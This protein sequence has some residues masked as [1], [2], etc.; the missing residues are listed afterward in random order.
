[1]EGTA[2]SERKVHLEKHDKGLSRVFIFLMVVAI[3]LIVIITYLNQDLELA[4]IAAINLL[5]M[6][7]VVTG[8]VAWVKRGDLGIITGKK[9]FIGMWLL[10]LAFAVIFTAVGY[11]SGGF[12]VDL[13]IPPSYSLHIEIVWASD[14][15]ANVLLAFVESVFIA[16]MSQLVIISVGFGFIWFSGWLVRTFLPSTLR[17]LNRATFTKSDPPTTL[18]LLWLMAIPRA[19]EP[20]SLAVEIGERPRT[21]SW[22]R[23]FW[24]VSWELFIGTILAIYIS[25]NP[26]LLDL[27]SITGLLST[28]GL[29]SVI[30]P[31]IVIPLFVIV[32]I[33]ARIPGPRAAFLLYHGI[34]SRILQTFVAL[35]T[36]FLLIRLALTKYDPIMI[37]QSFLSYYVILGIF[38]LYF[39]FVYLNFF[40]HDLAIKVV[41]D[42]KAK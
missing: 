9:I 28:L 17:K 36:I 11:S 38:C 31:V 14:S 35:G 5:N 25:F 32:A 41:D 23:F 21:Y 8:I 6:A 12:A 18:I 13:G 1:M 16:M 34:R 20:S 37:L 40:E 26:V 15:I 39:T 33:R 2:E 27:L 3:V 29:F 42:F 30:I 7:F 19:L 22:N 10:S 24:I 4:E